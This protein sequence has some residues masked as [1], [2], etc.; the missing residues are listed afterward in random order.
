MER[1]IELKINNEVSNE[2][3]ERFTAFLTPCLKG[4]AFIEEVNLIEKEEVEV[5]E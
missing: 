1:A 3:L 5:S 4:F 2:E